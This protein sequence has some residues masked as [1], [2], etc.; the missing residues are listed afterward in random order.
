MKNFMKRIMPIVMSVVLLTSF[1]ACFASAVSIGSGI[2]ALRAQWKRSAGPS[3]GGYSI[4]YSYFTPANAE[5]QSGGLPLFVFMAGAGEGSRAGK[6]LTANSFANWSSDEFQARVSDAS[7]AYLQILRAPEPVYFDTC[8]TSSMFAAIDDFASKNNVDRSRIYLVGWCIGACGVAR[9]AL[10]YPNSFAGVVFISMR[11]TISAS[12]A[13]KLKNMKVWILGCKNDSY[14][15]YSTY[16]SPSWDN[17]KSKTVNKANIRFTSCSSAPTAGALFNHNL[18]ILAE[19]DYS[20]DSTSNYSGLK[21]IDGNGN[22]LSSP[23]FISWLS[24]PSETAPSVDDDNDVSQSTASNFFKKF[25]DFFLKL[26]AALF[27]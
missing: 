3:K 5:R 20:S 23:S 17:I 27:S 25:I 10:A 21:T 2:D 13:E 15:L 9:L 11:T 4:E 22:V 1:L 14:S 26:L 7:G 19:N 8:P 18:W 16:T 24:A 12:E 6:E